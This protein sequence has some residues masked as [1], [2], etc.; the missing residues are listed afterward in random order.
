MQWGWNFIFK[1]L[2]FH[3]LTKTWIFSPPEALQKY[4]EFNE[5]TLPQRIVIYRDGVGE[6][7]IHTV[8]TH[9]VENLNSNLKRMYGD[10]PVK[11]TFIIVTK[12]INTRLFLNGN[13]PPP[14]TVAD[15]CVT[16][17]QRW[18]R[19]CVSFISY[20]LLQGCMSVSG[21]IFLRN[22]QW[23]WVWFSGVTWLWVFE[24]QKWCGDK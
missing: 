23:M 10:L 4:K 18:V 12:R 22:V 5:G 3:N 24:V 15:D 17:P 13:N 9:E 1:F 20:E 19:E 16:M 6:G 2:N 21:G 14:G 7:D 11:M 8:C